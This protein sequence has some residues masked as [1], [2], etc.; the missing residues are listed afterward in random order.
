MGTEDRIK[1]AVVIP[2][3]NRAALLAKC[4]D[5]LEAQTFPISSIFVVDNGSTDNTVDIV[6]QHQK[7]VL[8]R[9]EKNVGIDAALAIGLERAV[10]SGADAVFITDDDSF[11]LPSTL[12][13][14]VETMVRLKFRAVVNA[15]P[16][17]TMNGELISA[18]VFHGRLIT[19]K[20][21]FVQFYGRIVPTNKVHFN[22]SLISRV[23]LET[24]GLPDARF[25]SGEE[26][27]YGERIAENGF[28][29][30]ID[31]EANLLHPPMP[32]RMVRLPLI[33]Y[34]TAWDLPEW[35]AEH[36]PSNALLRRRRRHGLCRFLLID[37]P[38]VWIVY[39]IRLAFERHRKKKARLYLSS[40]WRGTWQGI[41]FSR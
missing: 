1:L 25:F 23:I 20:R 15:L 21:D 41:G 30:V 37:V 2:T 6:N 4:L 19:T 7:A 35:K 28:D 16:L 10:H 39:L 8:I 22:G 32:F 36:Y 13:T 9:L 24:V 34:F 5:S 33:G 29:I 3:R 26:T 17:V 40:L 12:L 11:L 27:G 31:A 38:L 18:R 14:L